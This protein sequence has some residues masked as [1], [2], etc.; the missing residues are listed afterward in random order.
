MRGPDPLHQRRRQ[1]LVGEGLDPERIV[2]SLDDPEAGDDHADQLVVEQRLAPRHQ[3]G[4]ARLDEPG[5]EL[6]PDPVRAVQHRVV[7]PRAIRA[8]PIAQQVAHHPFGLAGLVRERVGRHAVL[9]FAGGLEPLVE[10]AA[11][12]GHQPPRRLEDLARAAPVQVEDDRVA[13]PEVVAE[14]AEDGGIGA[15]PGEDRLLVVAHGEAVVVPRGQL[16]HDFVLGQAQV[17]ELVHQHIVPTAADVGARVGVAAEQLAGAGDEVVVVHQV[18]RAQGLAVRLEQ[19]AVAGGERHVL[20]PV[21]AEELQQLAVPLRAH[22]EAPEH[23][24][25]VVLVGDAEP[26]PEAR[27]GRVIAQQA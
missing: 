18:A 1:H 26:A 2:R 13:D 9:R 22:P 6:L 21:Q 23:A 11:V 14:P 15:G 7:A 10:Q 17:L 27:G 4:D 25:L 24:P 12:V 5:L 16:G 8:R 20:Q 3:A 19:L